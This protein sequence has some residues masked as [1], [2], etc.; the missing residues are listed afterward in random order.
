MEM[1]A[2]SPIHELFARLLDGWTPQADEID[3]DVTQIDA[4]NW[5]W[6]DAGRTIE[7]QTPARD[8]RVSSEIVYID[9]HRTFALTVD[10]MLWLYDDEESEKVRYLGG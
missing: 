6:S 1:A 7:Y 5:R 4:L 9:Q 2:M 3:R 8:H 10:A